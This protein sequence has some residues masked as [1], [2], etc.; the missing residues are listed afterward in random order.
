MEEVQENMRMMKSRTTG[1]IVRR[2]VERMQKEGEARGVVR[3]RSRGGYDDWK[4][5]AE[6]ARAGKEEAAGARGE[7]CEV[8]KGRGSG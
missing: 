6:R 3:Q 1:V 2:I 8:W 7:R 4:K 5:R